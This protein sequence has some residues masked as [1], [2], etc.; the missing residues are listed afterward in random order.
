MPVRWRRESVFYLFAL[1]F[2]GLSIVFGIWPI[3][4]SMEVSFTASATALRRVPTFV[5]LANYITVLGDPAFWQSLWLTLVYA[6]LAV[7]ANLGFALAMALL[8]NS[9]FITVG[10]TAFKLALFL[11]V[12]TPDVA[13]YVVWRWL[14]DQSF[15]AVNAALALAG[16]P[17]FGGIASPDTAMLAVFPTRPSSRSSSSRPSWTAW[18]SKTVR[19]EGRRGRLN[20]QMRRDPPTWD[21][22]AFCGFSFTGQQSFEGR[23]S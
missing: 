19:T 13:G 17:R 14:Y 23:G 7:A 22:T 11:P 8:L 1:P 3:L 5:G 6:A 20:L 12:V 16:L 2:A 4:L 18:R 10:R 21:R 9:R 15:G